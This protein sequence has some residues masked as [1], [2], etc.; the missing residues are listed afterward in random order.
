MGYRS[1]IVI[2]L[3]EEAAKRLHAEFKDV[4]EYLA[5]LGTKTELDDGGELYK[6]VNVKWD[7]AYCEDI[8]AIENFL[9]KLDWEDDECYEFMRLG[10]DD[11]DVEHRYTVD[12]VRLW[13]E[14][15]INTDNFREAE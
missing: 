12:D 4:E 9:D 2:Y 7:T 14:R 1:D 6:M 11:D 10:E 13:V 3:N 5:K 8:I 15:Y